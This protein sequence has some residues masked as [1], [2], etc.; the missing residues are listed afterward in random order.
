MKIY[1]SQQGNVE[2][3]FKR[4]SVIFNNHVI[5]NFPQSV[6]VKEFLK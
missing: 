2:T 1:I 6:P 4:Y 3:Q 5:E